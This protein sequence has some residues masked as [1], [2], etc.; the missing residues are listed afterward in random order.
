MDPCVPNI[1]EPRPKAP[2]L[3]P[4]GHLVSR[5][6]ISTWFDLIWSDTSPPFY[7]SLGVPSPLLSFSPQQSRS[8]SSLLII[9]TFS[10]KAF[11][12]RLPLI[13]C[14][15][16]CLFARHGRDS[17]EWYNTLWLGRWPV[18]DLYTSLG[19]AK[20]VLQN[21]SGKNKKKN[22]SLMISNE[23]SWNRQIIR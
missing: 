2:G 20:I 15:I 13:S 14:L 6:N 17:I 23:I 1:D 4:V 22:K 3:P 19:V 7:N 12:S 11:H 16:Q 9:W 18:P 8:T 5:K 21:I 10:H